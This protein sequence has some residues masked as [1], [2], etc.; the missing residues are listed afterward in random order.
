MLLILE[1]NL[2]FMSNNKSN[3][4][5]TV[6]KD[7]DRLNEVS[8]DEFDSLVNKI[9]GTLKSTNTQVKKTLDG[10]ILEEMS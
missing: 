2:K 4:E 7:I 10:H 6:L 8:G 1:L 3:V 5:E 9:Q